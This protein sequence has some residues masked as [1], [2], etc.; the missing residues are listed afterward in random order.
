LIYG[1]PGGL[2]TFP[3]PA[4]R[5]LDAL[6]PERTDFAEGGT[7]E[8]EE[9]EDESSRRRVFT[10]VVADEEQSMLPNLLEGIIVRYFV[11]KDP[12][13]ETIQQRTNRLISKNV[14]IQESCFFV[15]EVKVYN[16]D[17]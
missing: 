2:A 1:T 15:Y 6:G 9:E 3:L 4:P 14:A 12:S 13:L 5:V 8:G 16:E 11:V 7:P 17:G 10:L